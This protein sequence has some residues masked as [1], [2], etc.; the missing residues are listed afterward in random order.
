MS[1]EIMKTLIWWA[2]ILKSLNLKFNISIIPSVGWMII[3]DQHQKLVLI[4]D[5]YLSTIHKYVYLWI[6]HEEYR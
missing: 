6:Y 5:Q 3:P 4:V 2:L 1:H